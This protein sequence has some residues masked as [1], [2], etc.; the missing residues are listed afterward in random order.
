MKTLNS[1]SNDV[2]GLSA[3]AVQARAHSLRAV[4]VRLGE[5][6]RAA[7]N[8]ESFIGYPSSFSGSRSNPDPGFSLGMDNCQSPLCV[9]F[10]NVFVADD[11]RAQWIH[12]HHVGFSQNQPWSNPKKVNNNCQNY[13][14]YQLQKNLKPVLNNKDTVESEKSKQD[15]GDSGPGKVASWPEGFIHGAIIAGETK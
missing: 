2:R 6:D 5:W 1:L 8:T 14:S 7:I 9:K 4:R 12:H 10:Q 15:Q 11:F 13:A 3:Q